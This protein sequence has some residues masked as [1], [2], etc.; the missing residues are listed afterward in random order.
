MLYALLVYRCCAPQSCPTKLRSLLI[1]VSGG[2]IKCTAGSPG[3]PG[4]ILGLD[5]AEL[6]ALIKL[7]P[8]GVVFSFLFPFTAGSTAYYQQVGYLV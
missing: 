4:I 3:Q 8:K 1:R 2:G 7:T 6:L 5:V